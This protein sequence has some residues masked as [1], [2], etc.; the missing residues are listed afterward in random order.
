MA[1]LVVG[2][3]EGPKRDSGRQLQRIHWLARTR[4]SEICRSGGE[5]G[6]FRQTVEAKSM[7]S[8][9]PL[10]SSGSTG[11]HLHGA[12][13]SFWQTAAAKSIVL[14]VRG[15]LQAQNVILA[16]GCNEINDF[17]GCGRIRSEIKPAEP[18]PRGGVRGLGF[19]E[20]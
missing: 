8:G 6:S 2:K 7:V 18:V 9:V 11:E 17:G 1:V 5:Q 10:G 19:F 16:Y 12:Q 3:D 13:S 20:Y 4:G 15:W 14:R